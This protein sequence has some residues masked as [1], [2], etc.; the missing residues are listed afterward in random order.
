MRICV[1]GLADLT[2]LRHA[3]CPARQLGEKS[4]SWSERQLE[5]TRPNIYDAWIGH[6][7]CACDDGCHGAQHSYNWR[8]PDYRFGSE[9]RDCLY[10]LL[11]PHCALQPVCFAP[12]GSIGDSA[13]HDRRGGRH[14]A[15]GINFRLACRYDAHH[16][17]RSC[18]RKLSADCGRHELRHLRC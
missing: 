1:L 17:E 16:A 8:Q 15:G 6:L 2:R 14:L 18:L 13:S 4:W 9:L 10:E 3:T 11:R 12:S 5:R 7:R